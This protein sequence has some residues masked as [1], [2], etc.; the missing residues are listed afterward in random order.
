MRLRKKTSQR[1]ELNMNK[2]TCSDDD[3]VNHSLPSITA[4]KPNLWKHLKQQFTTHDKKN[5]CCG[6]TAPDVE[7]KMNKSLPSKTKKIGCWKRLKQKFTTHDKKNKCCGDIAPD[8]E[9]KMNKSLPSKTK[10]MGCWKRLKQ[11]FTTHEKKSKCCGDIAPDVNAEPKVINVSADE[12]D[13]ESQV[14]NTSS[15][16]E[17]AESQATNTSSDEEDAESQATNTS[18]DEEDAESQATNIS[19]DEEPLTGLANQFL[20]DG[21]ILH[22]LSPLPLTKGY[23][24]SLRHGED[25]STSSDEHRVLPELDVGQVVVGMWQVIS[26]IGEGGFGFVYK[27]KNV[28]SAKEVALKL[29]KSEGDVDMFLQFYYEID[30]MLKLHHQNIVDIVFLCEIDY[31]MAIL[32][33]YVEGG[34]LASQIHL[35]RKRTERELWCPMKQMADAVEYMHSQNIVHRDITPQNVLFSNK[36]IVKVI[37]FK[38]ARDFLTRG[39]KMFTCCGTRGYMAPEITAHGYEGPPVDVWALGVLF[40]K[41]FVGLQFD[42]RNIIET[43]HEK[44]DFIVGNSSPTFARVTL[45]SLLTAMLRKDPMERFTMTEIVNHTWFKE[46]HQVEFLWNAEP[47]VT[48]ESIEEEPPTDNTGTVDNDN[49]S[50]AA[51]HA[52]QQPPDARV[53]CPTSLLPLFLESAHTV[54]MI[55]HSMDVVKNAVEHL[56]PGQTPVVT[57][58]QPLFALAK[59]IQWKWPESYGEDQIVVMF[60]GLHIEMAALRTLGDW[61]KGSGWVQALVQAEIVTAG[62]ADSFLRASH[63]LRT[64]RAHQVTAAALYILQHRAYNHYCFRSEWNESLSWLLLPCA[65][66]AKGRVKHSGSS[67]CHS[68]DESTSSDEHRVLPELYVGQV[69]VGMWEVISKIGEGSFGFVYKAKNVISAKEGALKLAKSVGDGPK[70][71]HGANMMA[72]LH[73]QNIIKL[74]DVPIKHPDSDRA[75]LVLEYVESGSLASQIH[76]LRKR[77]ERELWCP[78]KQMADAV[79]YMHSQNIVHRDIKLDNVL[80]SHEGIVKVIDFDLATPFIHGEKFYD[81]WGTDYYMAPEITEDGYEGPPVDVWALGILFKELFFGLEFDGRNW[82]ETDFNVGNSSPTCTRVTLV[83]LLNAMLEADPME[84]FTMTEIVNHPWFKENHPVKF[85]RQFRQQIFTCCENQPQ[86]CPID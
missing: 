20:K 57:V 83:S 24:S 49:T 11:K 16:E 15:D 39:E 71:L 80:Y 42:G 61:L 68:E 86:L 23:G 8:V 52:S 46:N 27:A 64:R 66:E 41:L 72:K 74:L 33:E 65:H 5:K 4:K 81:V 32:L 84:R 12:E 6:D 44:T 47:K 7:P 78:M 75:V 63:V 35:L 29:P 53:I 59:Q 45:V 48:N 55:R 34:T 10:K 36:G 62:T 79:E 82:I 69:V 3:G 60:G 77:T 54:A 37:D 17:D 70:M 50:W 38:A 18:S 19:A 31:R 22:V 56:N 58:D 73:H 1:R 9:P 43:S 85:Y 21:S 26:K 30:I 28:I 14:T 2:S 13:A 67:L 76:L 51:F 40:T 25:E